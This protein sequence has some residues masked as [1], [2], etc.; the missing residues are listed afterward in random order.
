MCLDLSQN[1]IEYVDVSLLPRLDMLNLDENR[2]QVIEGLD[3]RSMSCLSWRNQKVVGKD[4]LQYDHCKDASCLAVSGNRIPNLSPQLPFWSLRRLEVAHC[5]IQE[6]DAS[7]GT[8]MPNLRIL[9]LNHNAIKDLK[10]LLGICFL[11]ELYVAGNRIFRLRQT[12]SMLGMLGAQLRMF[13]CRNNPLTIG[14]YVPPS[15]QRADTKTM[16]PKDKYEG[17][18]I[19][20][21][22][23]MQLVQQHLLPLGNE[24]ADQKYLETLDQSTAR[25]RLVWEV[26]CLISGKALENLDG[27]TVERQKLGQS[28]ALIA[29]LL[30]LGVL[31]RGEAPVLEE[32]TRLERDSSVVDGFLGSFTD[33]LSIRVHG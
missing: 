18:I 13:D 15:V 23:Q 25:R 16:V 22:E 10:P 12:A 33:D 31:Q 1:E 4:D 21:F 3:S 17:S 19:G 8:L 29:R 6:L 28:Q 20:G 11:E 2:I 30:E 32:A 5:G 7:F 26:L 14:Y 24:E 9:N 27:L